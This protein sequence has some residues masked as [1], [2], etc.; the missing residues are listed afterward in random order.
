M[1]VMVGAYGSTHLSEGAAHVVY[2][3]NT[4][5]AYEA[6]FLDLGAGSD[7]GLDGNDGFTLSGVSMEYTL[8]AE[9]VRSP[10]DL[11]VLRKVQC[12]V[13]QCA[14]RRRCKQSWYDAP[15]DMWVLWKVPHHPTAEGHSDTQCV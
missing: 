1:D 7:G 2:G 12:H 15:V 4:S 8:Y 9:L 13:R 6:S 5:A 10:V 11:E 14:S 3:T